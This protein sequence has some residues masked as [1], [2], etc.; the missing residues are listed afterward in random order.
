MCDFT[1]N[2]IPAISG[3]TFGK[4]KFVLLIFNKIPQELIFNLV[5]CVC[6]EF[7]CCACIAVKDSGILSDS[8]LNPNLTYYAWIIPEIATSFLFVCLFGV[9]TC[10]ATSK[11]NTNRDHLLLT[12]VYEGRLT[13]FN[14]IVRCFSM[15]ASNEVPVLMNRKISQH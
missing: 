2:V 9:N 4:G 13:H 5:P 8:E 7:M 15:Q 11:H 6:V 1:A 12:E 3:M 10:N 14:C